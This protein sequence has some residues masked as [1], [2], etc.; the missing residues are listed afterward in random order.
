MHLIEEY[1]LSINQTVVVH[2]LINGLIKG[3]A[4]LHNT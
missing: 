4:N 1:K 2:K 3:V